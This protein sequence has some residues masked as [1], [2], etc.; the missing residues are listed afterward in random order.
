MWVTDGQNTSRAYEQTRLPI[1]ID[2]V[3]TN[4]DYPAQLAVYSD[5]LYFSA[6]SDQFGASTDLQGTRTA[7]DLITVSLSVAHGSVSL[8]H[9]GALSFSVGSG[10]QDSAVEFTGTLSNLNAALANAIYKPALNWNSE[11]AQEM[12]LIAITASDGTLSTS[13]TLHVR[14]LP[15]NDAPVL[16][17]PGARYDTIHTVQDDLSLKIVDVSTMHVK[18]DELAPIKG[19]TIR[20]VDAHE[21]DGVENLIEVALYTSHGRLSVDTS[22][23]V[24]AYLAGNGQDD[25]VIVFHAS[26]NTANLALQGLSYQGDPNYHGEDEIIITV[27]DLGNSGYLSRAQVD[28]TEDDVRS[29]AESQTIPVLVHPTNDLPVWHLPSQPVIAREDVAQPLSGISVTDVDIR[30]E[31]MR[32]EEV[33]IAAHIQPRAA[34]GFNH[35]VILREDGSVSTVGAGEFGQLGLSSTLDTTSL[36]SVDGAGVVRDIA[37]GA[38]HSVLVMADGTVQVFG[39]GESGQLGLG[40][41]DCF[42]DVHTDHTVTSCVD[43]CKAFATLEEAMGHCRSVAGCGGISSREALGGRLSLPFEVRSR[44]PLEVASREAFYSRLS[45]C[46][47]EVPTPIAG[48]TNVIEAAAGDAHTILVLADGTVFTFGDGAFGQLGHGDYIASRTPKRIAGLTGAHHAA[49]GGRHSVLLFEDGTVK[50]FGDDSF[51]QLGHGQYRQ[52]HSDG[53]TLSMGEGTNLSVPTMINQTDVL[54]IAG[55]DAHTVL[56]VK[57]CLATYPISGTVIG[58]E[59]VRVKAH[60]RPHDVYTKTGQCSNSVMTFGYGLNGQLGHSGTQGANTATTVDGLIGV[61]AIAAGAQHTVA[62]MQ[63]CYSGPHLGKRIPTCV[64]GCRAFVTLDDAIERCDSIPN[65][66]GVTLRSN[67]S[68]TPNVYAEVFELRRGAEIHDPSQPDQHEPLPFDPAHYASEVSWVKQGSCKG[69]IRT[70][71]RGQ[72]GQLGH[73]NTVNLNAPATV[74]ND[75]LRAQ[76]S[77]TVWGIQGLKGVRSLGVGRSHTVLVMDDGTVMTFGEGDGGQLGQGP[78]GRGALRE[79]SMLSVP[80]TVMGADGQRPWRWKVSPAGY[81]ADQMKQSDVLPLS[82]LEGCHVSHQVTISAM[83]GSIRMSSSVNTNVTGG[84]NTANSLITFQGTLN[85]VNR[86]IATVVYLPYRDWNSDGRAFEEIVLTI[87]DLDAVGTSTVEE[88]LQIHVLAVNDQPQVHLP[89]MHLRRVEPLDPRKSQATTED[90]L[91]LTNVET[92]VVEEDMRLLIPGVT[93]EDPDL[94]SSNTMLQ[95]TITA[96]HGTVEL[97]GQLGLLFL[98]GQGDTRDPSMVVKGSAANLNLALT[99]LRYTPAADYNGPDTIAFTVSDLGN[100]GE[101]GELTQTRVLPIS[102]TPVN[103]APSWTVQSSALLI[104]EG[105]DTVVRGVAI[106][107]PDVGAADM[108]LTVAVSHGAVAFT[109]AAQD[110]LHFVE[111]NGQRENRT[112]VRGTLADLNIFL[113]DFSFVPAPNWDHTN[114]QEHA[115]I[116]LTVNDFGAPGSGGGRSV[117]HTLEVWRASAVNDAPV[118]HVPGATLRT[119]PCEDAQTGGERTDR[120]TGADALHMRCGRIINVATMQVQ[121]DTPLRIH[122]IYI[123]DSDMDEIRGATIVVNAT[124]QHGMLTVSNFAGL[125]FLIGGGKEDGIRRGMLSFEG[126]LANV[127][128][129][130]AELQYQVRALCI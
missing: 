6:G 23:S 28:G 88:V 98:H 12:D 80:T 42:S 85:D 53:Y 7:G 9:V 73:G 8:A 126:T 119:A 61:E 4:S 112:V 122:N 105:G 54:Q 13:K 82:H 104:V 48:L 49:A 71:G 44:G 39:L 116:T 40:L 47:R 20:D 35:T 120:N 114:A 121:E 21:Q 106:V 22:A 75:D 128:R 127:N 115:T 27:D 60:N 95:L 83:H 15:Q 62:L 16:D 56:L 11:Y 59:Y 101:G 26:V 38:F 103:D 81:L 51:G 89:G 93:I 79:D 74:E 63:H 91:T 78:L 109:P 33:A 50:T 69:M 52:V 102:V 108:E 113:R 123:E 94:S 34:G 97:G 118:V 25:R 19:V 46:H 43:G 96:T 5:T 31:C 55:G 66:D 1:A 2:T 100:T 70:F 37:A 41:A 99:G 64:E 129:A 65:C 3:A 18:E 68:D 58:N 111:G 17:L 124:A 117:T 45:H 57:A 130:L 110:V 87:K 107:D 84:G 90:G 125:M 86:A 92:L 14:V 30:E 76:H 32:Q 72:L 10:W 77:S 24:Q 29:L 67:K 36:A